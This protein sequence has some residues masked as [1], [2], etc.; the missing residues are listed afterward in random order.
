MVPHL[1]HK[2]HAEGKP[3][4]V[5]MSQV[6]TACWAKLLSDRPNDA[7]RNLTQQDQRKRFGDKPLSC[8]NEGCSLRALGLQLQKG[9]LWSSLF[10]I[11]GLF[12]F[13]KNCGGMATLQILPCKSQMWIKPD[14]HCVCTF[15]CGTEPE[16]FISER[17]AQL[18]I[19]C[20]QN[21]SPSR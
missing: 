9:A 21:P 8:C 15:Y 20:S 10:I 5:G 14:W 12:F 7:S 16:K 2:W 6:P 4:L 17:R 18:Q 11:K 1:H 3:A 13:G 19:L